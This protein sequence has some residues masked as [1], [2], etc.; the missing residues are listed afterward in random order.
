MTNEK[1]ARF[2]Q[3]KWF[4][5]WRTLKEGYDYFE[6]N[7]VPPSVAV[8]ERRYV[9]N[10]V[11]PAYGRLDPAGRCPRFQRPMLE[12]FA[13]KPMEGTLALQKVT[14]PGP[15]TRNPAEVEAAANLA[16]QIQAAQ[17]E[18]SSTMPAASALG[19]NQ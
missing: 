14:V 6:V 7:R 18:T 8:C 5:F 16:Q 15:K 2:Q 1:L 19:F 11:P 10:V 9:V 12:P 4:A 17:T 3:H 13:P